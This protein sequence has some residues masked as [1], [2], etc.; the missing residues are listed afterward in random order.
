MELVEFIK[1]GI[2]KPWFLDHK[3]KTVIHKM[4]IDF[5]ASFGINKF[6]KN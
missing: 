5:A 2:F 1:K 3:R 4:P 6:S